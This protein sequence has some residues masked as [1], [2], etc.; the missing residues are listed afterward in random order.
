MKGFAPM[1]TLPITARRFLGLAVVM[2][3]SLASA[4]AAHAQC[5]PLQVD[6]SKLSAHGAPH[7]PLLPESGHLSDAVYTSDF[8][9]FAL[10][11][12][13]AS[14]GHLIKLPLMPERQHA[15]LAI[16][17]Q[18]GDRSGSLTIDAID[19]REGL[20]GFS[21]EQQQQ[22]Q[23]LSSRPPGT[24]QSERSPSR[25]TSHKSARKAR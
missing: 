24:L 2:V 15:L 12:P 14:H 17:Y 5:A 1:S 8:F 6:P 16:A 13:I 23:Q 18:N 9:G 25:R 7:E 20:E 11:L 4:S 21:T 10:D 19:P 22:Q 3:L